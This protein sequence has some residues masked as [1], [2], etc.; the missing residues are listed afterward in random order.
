M[1]DLSRSEIDY[2]ALAC[3]GVRGLT[4]YLPGKPSEE[5]E[6][7]L[8]ISNIVKLAS[9]E[10]PLGPSEHAL[11]AIAQASKEL[12]RYPDGNGFSLKSALHK[13][14]G[15]DPEL[16][17]L[18]NGSN[19]LLDLITRAY[20]DAGKEVIFS[21]YAFAVY[22]LST[23]AVGATAVVT[24]AKNWGHDLDAM[25]AAITDRT[26][27]IFIANPNN[28]TGTALDEA[29]L[30]LFLERVPAHI[31]VVLD[32]AYSEYSLDDAFPDGLK[33]MA[34][35]SNL[36]VTRTFSKAWGLGALRVGYAVANA[37]I[38]D[39]LNRVRHPFNVNSLALAAAT[40]VLDDHEY[41]EK[42]REINAFGLVQLVEGF[43][44]LGLDYIPSVGNFICVDSKQDAADL[45][46]RLLH[47]GVI[48]RPVGNYGMP[49]HLRV[50]VGLPEENQRFL[51]ALEKVL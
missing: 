9:N 12:T 35:Y 43:D 21:Q 23:R 38:T 18:G 50:S 11:Q 40:A 41:L 30:R 32:E 4:P 6:R 34:D 47:E 45:Y 25:L 33:L 1:G 3:D 2:I 37:E 36:V 28:P 46:Q 49:Q 29:A 10:N 13:R 15:I 5:L 44:R 24:P 39:V 22:A 20:A 42:G 31:I 48:V 17:T 14:F 27:L 8:G 26:R 16:I 7:E 19:D 51:D